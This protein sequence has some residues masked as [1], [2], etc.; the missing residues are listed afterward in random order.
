MTVRFI[1]GMDSSAP[2]CTT[3]DMPRFSIQWQAKAD[4][5]PPEDALKRIAESH[6]HPSHIPRAGPTSAMTL[7]G[8]PAPS[9]KGRASIE[10]PGQTSRIADSASGDRGSR[11]NGLL[12]TEG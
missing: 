11:K 5:T 1:Q 3:N 9:G 10:I 4:T 2:V 12:P 7:S 8:F 6:D